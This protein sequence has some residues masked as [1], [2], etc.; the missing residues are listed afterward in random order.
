LKIGLFTRTYYEKMKA[1]EG[2][3]DELT[4]NFRRTYYEKPGF[5]DELTMKNGGDITIYNS[6]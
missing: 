5:L 6:I 3:L 4:M 2:L 1:P